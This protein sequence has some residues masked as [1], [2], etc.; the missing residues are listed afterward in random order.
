MLDKRSQAWLSRGTR[1]TPSP[2]AFPPRSTQPAQ[3]QLGCVSVFGR[4][5]QLFDSGGTSIA[6]HNEMQT[7]S[8]SVGQAVARGFACTGAASRNHQTAKNHRRPD[9]SARDEFI[10]LEALEAKFKRQAREYQRILSP[11]NA[12]VTLFCI[13]CTYHHGPCVSCTFRNT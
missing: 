6:H 11:N 3:L 13:I 7:T 10:C 1:V 2:V 9:P 12:S 4:F 5:K 8:E